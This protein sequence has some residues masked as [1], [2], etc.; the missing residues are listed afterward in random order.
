MECAND[1]TGSKDLMTNA[2]VNAVVPIVTYINQCFSSVYPIEACRVFLDIDHASMFLAKYTI[3]ND[4]NLRHQV[5]IKG[6]TRQDC[7]FSY[8]IILDDKSKLRLV[9]DFELRGDVKKGASVFPFLHVFYT[10]C[11]SE[12]N[13]VE[14]EQEIEDTDEELVSK[15]FKF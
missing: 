12:T 11:Y 6:P 15:R 2:C 7:Y 10:L 3:L 9:S 13:V 8:E 5:I 4:S 1:V 14:L